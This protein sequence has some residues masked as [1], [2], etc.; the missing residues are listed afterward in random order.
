MVSLSL[1]LS[2]T[3]A[4]LNKRDYKLSY[5]DLTDQLWTFR[6][7][8][9]SFELDVWKNSTIIDQITFSRWLIIDDNRG[10]RAS[11][12]AEMHRL[13][14][15]NLQ[16]GF[17]ML[18]LGYRPNKQL[19]LGRPNFESAL[20]LF[21]RH[22]R[23][24]KEIEN[25]KL[26]TKNIQT[27]AQ[28]IQFVVTCFLSTFRMDQARR[29]WIASCCLRLWEERKI[30]NIKFH[31]TNSYSES[32]N[33]NAMSLPSS[34]VSLSVESFSLFAL[35][36]S[37]EWW[38]SHSIVTIVSV[39]LIFSPSLPFALILFLFLFLSFPLSCYLIHQLQFSCLCQV[40][41]SPVF[42]LRETFDPH[43]LQLTLFSL[44]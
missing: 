37:C 10:V 40:Q 31:T 20:D 1:S 3:G 39:Y 15:W 41:A 27:A 11:R 32:L 17:Y 14:N 25:G 36:Y 26:P 6:F 23:W 24:M 21:A 5:V 42:V 18:R 7:G 28:I 13:L 44:T 12:V 35:F 16:N 9:R 34:R 33:W 2:K 19:A 30:L 22:K 38:G 4:Q 43:W 8:P 29:D